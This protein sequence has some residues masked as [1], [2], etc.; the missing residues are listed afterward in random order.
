MAT[1][2]N[3]SL[4]RGFQI[5]EYLGDSTKGRA[6]SEVARATGLH[7]ATAHRLLEVLCGMGYAYKAE[8]R[9]YWIGYN[10]QLFGNRSNMV[11]RITH[12]A[13]PFL[14]TLAHEVD[15]TVALG[16]LEGIQV[17]IADRVSTDRAH[18]SAV[19]IGTYFD[20]HSTSLGKALLS[21]RPINEVRA[22]YKNTRLS[23]YTGKTI[24]DVDSLLRD[25]SKIKKRGYSI[26]DEEGSPGIRSVS[27]PVLNLD[28]RAACSLAVSGPRARLD[29]SKIERVGVRLQNVA[30][31][32]VAQVVKQ[33]G[34]T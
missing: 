10:A 5:L 14:V 13:H 7:R 30:S 26:S 9:R 6:V 3:Q 25:L 20:A 31:E 29:D 17:F 32:I 27:A 2:K 21:V 15:E 34:E 1:Y 16:F 28:G 24:T 12:H 33:G 8:D 4:E 11:A 18:R 23:A 19:Q 22:S